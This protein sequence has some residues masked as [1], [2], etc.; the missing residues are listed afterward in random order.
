M[1][2]GTSGALGDTSRQKAMSP[3]SS[4]DFRQVMIRAVLFDID[5]TLLDFDPQAS[6]HAFR[7]GAERTYA[8]LK[9]RDLAVPTFEKFLKTH[10]SLAWRMKWIARLTGKEQSVRHVLRKLCLKLRLQRDEVSLSRLG[11]LWYEPLVECCTIAPDVVPTLARL[12]DAGLKLGLVCNTPL[13]GDVIDKHLEL[14]GLLDFFPIRIYSSDVGYR[15]PDVRT[16]AAA[17][18][19]LHV[20]P[21]EAMYVGDV[22]KSDMAGAHKAGIRTVLRQRTY[23]GEFCEDADHTIRNIAELLALAPLKAA[24]Q[25]NPEPEPSIVN[26][27]ARPSAA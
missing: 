8:Y 6:R 4:K 13:Q 12:R 23:N 16:F 18:R 26:T 11:W 7:I 14:E 24:L 27:S 9:S 19:E 3:T 21:N 2:L 5:D 10:C 1:N 17:L 25:C 22:P 20:Q 15:K